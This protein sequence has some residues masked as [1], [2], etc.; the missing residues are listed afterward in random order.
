MQRRQQKRC[1]ASVWQGS[2]RRKGAQAG[3]CTSRRS[4]PLDIGA[5]EA[6]GPTAPMATNARCGRIESVIDF[7]REIDWDWSDPRV[8][9]WGT[10][11]TFLLSFLGF[12]YLYHQMPMLYDSDSYFHMAVA[13]LYGKCVGA[14][15][16]V[17]Y[18]DRN[19]GSCIIQT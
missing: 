19:L 11:A 6:V 17:S 9:W 13:R 14:S 4:G 18:I 2:Q 16:S 3:T 10:L 12:T 5:I 15:P 8:L 7:Q 1:S